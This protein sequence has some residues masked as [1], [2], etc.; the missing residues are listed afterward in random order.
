MFFFTKQSV[1][2]ARILREAATL[3]FISIYIQ[4]F[5]KSHYLELVIENIGN[6][7]AY[8]IDINFDENFIQKVHETENSIPSKLHIKYFSP[9]QSVA[10]FLCE[11]GK[12]P[13]DNDFSFNIDLSYSSKDKKKYLMTALSITILFLNVQITPCL[14]S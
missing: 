8:N 14:T 11:F 2:E 5:K 10:Y 1:K 7:P 12:L 13:Q 3:P 6:S 9:N 4:S